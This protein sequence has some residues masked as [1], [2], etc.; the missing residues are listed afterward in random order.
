M[1]QRSAGEDDG[2]GDGAV[3]GDEDIESTAQRAVV[4]DFEADALFAEQAENPGLGKLLSGPGAEQ[5]YRRFRFED[6][7]QL[8]GGEL[9]ERI[10]WPWAKQ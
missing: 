4:H 3:F 10:H 6:R 1:G 8:L 5:Y 7:R 2:G 9:L